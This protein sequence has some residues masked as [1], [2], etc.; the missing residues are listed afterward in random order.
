MGGRPVGLLHCGTYEY[1]GAISSTYYYCC[2][3]TYYVVEM[4]CTRQAIP[5]Y[6][7]GYTLVP[8]SIMRYAIQY[9]SV[10]TRCGVHRM[11]CGSNLFLTDDLDLL[12]VFGASCR[13]TAGIRFMSDWNMHTCVYY[14][15]CSRNAMYQVGYTLVPASIM[16]YAI[17]YKRCAYQVWYA[18]QDRGSNLLTDNL[19]LMVAFRASCRRT[20]GIRF[21]SDWNMH[22]CT[23]AVVEMQC[24][25]QAMPWYQLVSCDMRYH[26]NG[27]RTRCGMHHK[28]VDLIC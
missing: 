18:S 4:Q 5:W 25:R 12:V 17:P 8:G 22:T 16:R 3:C 24:T 13:R 2:T 9:S 26:T 20:A 6:Q 28:I 10:R 7:V 11:T 1:G 14:L 23:T 27:V 21:M 15:Q 19:D